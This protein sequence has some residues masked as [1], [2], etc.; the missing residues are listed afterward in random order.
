MT[1]LTGVNRIY[2]ATLGWVTREGTFALR[3]EC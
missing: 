1:A 2:V 3:V